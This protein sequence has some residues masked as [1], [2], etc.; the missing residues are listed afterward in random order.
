V[1]E[2]GA[3]KE[4]LHEQR[5][6]AVSCLVSPDGELLAVAFEGG[7]L[8]VWSL[9]GRQC[10]WR[11]ERAFTIP[12]LMEFSA[13]GRWFAYSADASGSV[14]LLDA[15]VGNEFG[16]LRGSRGQI[17]AIAFSLCGFWVGAGGYDSTTVVC[18]VSAL[19]GQSSPRSGPTFES[20]ENAWASLGGQIEVEYRDAFCYFLTSR[21]DVDAWLCERILQ[22]SLSDAEAEFQG[23]LPL[24]R[25]DSI[26]S[27]TRGLA[28]IRELDIEP[29]LRNA[30]GREIDGEVRILLAN[31]LEDRQCRLG[32]TRFDRRRDRAIQILKYRG[33]RAASEAL[34]RIAKC[35]PWP[36][37]ATS[38]RVAARRVK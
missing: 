9:R 23:A 30:V 10:L 14:R 6:G 17:T 22:Y 3:I 36:R 33:T 19:L 1:K 38:A 4:L 7:A 2:G 5:Q 8:G 20:L 24:L 26:E 18:R 31:A 32:F 28:E 27:R 25:S 29:A 13:D 21:M 12:P 34:D 37:L 35:S 11:R 16:E 15:Y